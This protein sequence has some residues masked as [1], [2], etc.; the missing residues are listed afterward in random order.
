MSLTPVPPII[1]PSEAASAV[2]GKV[3]NARSNPALLSLIRRMSALF[4]AKTDRRFDERIA[5]LKHDAFRYEDGGDLDSQVELLLR[6]DL[7]TLTSIT[8]TGNGGTLDI[9][10]DALQLLDDDQP[11]YDRIRLNPFGTQRF[12]PLSGVDLRGAIAVEGVWG[13]GGK[14]VYTGATVGTEQVGDPTLTPSALGLIEA[15]MVLKID[16][17]YQY[18]ESVGDTDVIVERAFNGSSANIHVA[19]TRIYRWKSHDLA[20]QAVQRLVAIA[21]EQNK[22]PLFGQLAL[23]DL[24]S[25]PV[26]VDAPSKDV[27]DIIYG[28]GLRRHRYPKAT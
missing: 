23:G 22:S 19:D 3:E 28:T 8:I 10:G 7:K 2:S 11:A 15:G 26:S 16:D 1:L 25:V 21:I 27:M 17:E 5:T 24:G 18:V 20:E 13:F 14:W 12:V 6:A 9:T 4:S